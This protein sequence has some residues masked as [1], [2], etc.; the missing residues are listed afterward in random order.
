M[1]KQSFV[2]SRSRDNYP[3]ISGKQTKLTRNHGKTKFP[4]LEIFR[5]LSHYHGKTEEIKYMNECLGLP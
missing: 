1:G 3:V 5:K 4:Y 2:I